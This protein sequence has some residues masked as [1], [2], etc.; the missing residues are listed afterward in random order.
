MQVIRDVNLASDETLKELPFTY[1]GISA[2]KEISFIPNYATKD[3][4][5]NGY[6]VNL[7]KNGDTVWALTNDYPPRLRVTSP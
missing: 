1:D 3:G 2:N 5:T 7:E 6:Q 4:S